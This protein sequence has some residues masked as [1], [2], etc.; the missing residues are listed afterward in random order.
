V[1]ESHAAAVQG[2]ALPSG[3]ARLLDR[4]LDAGVLLSLV[5][6]IVVFSVLSPQFLTV[7]NLINIADASAVVG[8][9]AVG[10][11]VALI[12]GQF[13]LSVGS[14]VGLSSSLLAL[15]MA[16]WGVPVGLA[17][18]LAIA[19]A[20]A[21]GAINGFLVV[22]FGIN[23]IIATLGMLAAVRGIAFV[24]AKGSPITVDS[25]FLIDIGV[26]RPLGIPV[27]VYVMAVAY[28]GAWILL[29][30]MRL[31]VHI[32]AVGGD[33]MAAER[34]GVRHR[35]VLRFV[36]LLASF[37][38]AIGAILI[39]AKSFSGQAVFGRSLELDVLTAVLLGGVGLRGGEGSIGK[40][41]IG[42]AIVGVLTNGLVL[43]QVEAY[44]TDVAR[45]G[46]LIIA[47]VLEAVREKR[48]RR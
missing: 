41:L 39:T 43:T 32:Y 14:V 20:L 34:A 27:A 45:G 2:R 42:V 4:I 11:T 10:M 31:G 44:W 36:F 6:L 17:I 38:A 7:D 30:Q 3:G 19:A 23:S 13:D 1:S 16:E 29:T 33:E 12:A 48:A 26:S 8:I 15:S 24:V 37:C 18:V 28:L 9:V 5:G 25:P 40:T 46:A 47:V 21:V 22:N 35:N